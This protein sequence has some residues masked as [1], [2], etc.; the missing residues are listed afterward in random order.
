MSQ[1]VPSSKPAVSPKLTPHLVVSG[2]AEAIEFY[3]KAFGAVETIRLPSPDGRLMHAAVEISGSAVMLVDE[4]PEMGGK[5]P[6]TLQ[7]TPVTL[8]LTVPDA[9]ATVDQAVA[10]GAKVIVA[11]ADAFWGD[12]YGQIEDPFGHRW[13]VATPIRTMTPAE[14]QESMRKAMG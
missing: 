2:A 12:R 5:S 3:K 8:H 6:K 4:F 7:G 1:S 9:D 14:I 11:V 13:S 10:A